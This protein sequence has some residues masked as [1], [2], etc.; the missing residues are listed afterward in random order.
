MTHPSWPAHH[1]VYIASAVGV[2]AGR[3]THALKAFT[4]HVGTSVDGRAAASTAVAGCASADCGL[5]RRAPSSCAAALA[6]HVERRTRRYVQGL[7][8]NIQGMRP[9]ATPD[10]DVV[11][12]LPE[13]VV[14]SV[15]Q[16]D[17]DAHKD[18][19]NGVVLAGAIPCALRIHQEFAKF[20]SMH[21]RIHE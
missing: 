7:V 2:I 4:G 18:L 10:G 14:D 9:V 6:S 16:T 13:L 3:S 21:D 12:G 5:W 17:I 8:R 20:P 15:N 11:K 1:D 19:F